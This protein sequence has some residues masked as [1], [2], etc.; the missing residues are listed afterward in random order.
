MYLL[1]AGA[2]RKNMF[3]FLGWNSGSQH[4]YPGRLEYAASENLPNCEIALFRTGVWSGDLQ[5]L[6]P[7]Y[8]VYVTL[9]TEESSSVTFGS[10][11]P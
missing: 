8:C 7:T 6:L 1:T 2:L 5:R 10:E 4:T 9:G 11:S 3:E